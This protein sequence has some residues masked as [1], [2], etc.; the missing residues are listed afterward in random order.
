MPPRKR[1]TVTARTASQTTDASAAPAR[2]YDHPTADAPLRPEVGTQTQFRK[3]K[4]PATYRYDSSLAPE[5]QWDGANAAQRDRFSELLA[6]VHA[7][8]AAEGDG[9]EAQAVRQ[10]ARDAARELERL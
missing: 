2:A 10:A 8:L 5:L 9:T 7:G 3:K 6:L 1:S 4:A